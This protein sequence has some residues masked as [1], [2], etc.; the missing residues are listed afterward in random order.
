M[1]IRQLSHV[2]LKSPDLAATRRFYCDAFGFEPVFSFTRNGAEYGYYLRVAERQ[3]IE[4]FAEN[5]V[6]NDDGQQV[7][8]HFCFE[9]DEIHALHARLTEAGFRPGPIKLG[10]DQ[11]QQFWVRDPSGMNLEVQEYTQHSAQLTGGV[12]EVDW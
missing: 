5:A 11:T 2:C 3:F 6:K 4:V 1:P 8:A 7:L 10:C 12:I 9:T